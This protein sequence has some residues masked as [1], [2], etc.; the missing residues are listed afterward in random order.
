MCD[1]VLSIQTVNHC[2]GLNRCKRLDALL[3]DAYFVYIGEEPSYKPLC[4]FAE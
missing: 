1:L 3:V 2:L 4:D